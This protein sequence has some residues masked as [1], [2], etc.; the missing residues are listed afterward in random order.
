MYTLYTS[1]PL[2]IV[3]IL[4]ETDSLLV[5]KSVSAYSEHFAAANGV[6]Y[7]ESL[8]YCICTAQKEY[9]LV[10]KRNIRID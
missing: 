9:V 4:S 6:H 3:N 10:H 8:L 5:L 7:M 1:E 2:H